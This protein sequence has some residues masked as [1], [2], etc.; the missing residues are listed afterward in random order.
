M[1]SSQDVSRLP[2][3]LLGLLLSGPAHS[4]S[5]W[6]QSEE[7]VAPAQPFTRTE[8]REPCADYQAARQPLFGDLHVHTSY[9]HD[10]Y[11]S[12]QRNDPWDAY[13]YA[14]GEVLSQPDANGVQT[15][16]AQISKP[17]DFTA[18][19][20]HAEYFGELNLCTRDSATFAYWMPQCM[21]N[22]GDNFFVPLLVARYWSG[23]SATGRESDDD[24][25]IICSVP[26]ADCKAAAA[27][28]WADIQQAAQDHY[29]RSA[30]C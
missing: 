20:D 13:R 18:V 6:A 9:S 5:L 27:E 17:L 3:I 26:G 4:V 15:V 23:L 12:M 14:R 16:R 28:T 7:R 24:R 29:D 25:S 2:R 22:R 19:T 30:A 1:V 11:V 21:I 10:A 8:Q